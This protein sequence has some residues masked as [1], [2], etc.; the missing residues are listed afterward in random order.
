MS[1]ASR[2]LS[3][4]PLLLPQQPR[5]PQRL[6]QPHQ[7]L[8]QQRLQP[9]PQQVVLPVVQLQAVPPQVAQ[10]AQVPELARERECLLELVRHICSRLMTAAK[11][12]WPMKLRATRNLLMMEAALKNPDRQHHLRTSQLM[13]AA[14]RVQPEASKSSCRRSRE[15]VRL[16]AVHQVDRQVVHLDLVHPQRVAHHLAVRVLDLR[17]NNQQMAVAKKRCQTM[18]ASAVCSRGVVR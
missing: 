14:A 4:L 7:Q 17:V 1:R 8:L 10:R 13:T 12:Q 9:L 3:P 11:T 2:R 6:P 18:E 16:K 5:R 15:L